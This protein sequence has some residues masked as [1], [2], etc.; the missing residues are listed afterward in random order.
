MKSWQVRAALLAAVAATLCVLWWT[1]ALAEL[2]EP[3]RV[4]VLLTETGVVGPLLWGLAFV[5]LQPFGMPGAAFMIPAAL[6]WPPALAIGLCVAGATGAGAF[7]FALARWIGSE[8]IVARL[9]ERVQRRTREARERGFRTAFLV[10]LVLFLFPPAHWALGISGI[11]FGPFLAGSA[12][13]FV[14]GTTVWVLATR[15]LFH[16]L[17]RLPL[18]EAAGLGVAALALG[19]GVLWW[20]RRRAR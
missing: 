8:A 16:Q 14:P 12:L 15:E 4:R 2:A 9:P 10:R 6:V 3:E 17:E 7:A 19:A 1:G 13:G 5:V 20:R 18:W 11:R